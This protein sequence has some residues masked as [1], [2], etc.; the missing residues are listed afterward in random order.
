MFIQ[1]PK[2]EVFSDSLV[3][4]SLLSNPPAARP[5]DSCALFRSPTPAGNKL[6]GH[7]TRVLAALGKSQDSA[8]WQFDFRA[9]DNEAGK[10]GP[11][12]GF[13]FHYLV[14]S[15][16]DGKFISPEIPLWVVSRQAAA[17]TSPKSLET[18]SSPTLAWTPVPGVPAYHLLLSDQAIDINASKGTVAGASVIWQAITTKASIAYGT[19]DPSGS[20]SQLP[21]PPLSPGVP[22]NLVILN[23]YDGRSALS[24]STK[25]QGLK[26][27]TLQAAAAPLQPARNVAPAQGKILTVSADSAITFKWSKAVAANGAGAA[28]TYQIFIYSLES[29]NGF[30][31]LVPIWHTEVTDT[32]AALDAKRTLLTKRYVWKVF[33]LNAAGASVVGDTTSF[34]YRN[35][36]QTLSLTVKSAGLAGDTLPL[37]DVRISVTPLDG[38]A[39]PLPLFTANNGDAEKV[40]AVGSYVLAFSKDGYSGQSRTVTLGTAAPLKLLQI[41]PSASCRITGHLADQTGSDLVNANVTA[42]GGG[43][44]VTSVSDAQGFFLLGVAPGTYA[45]SISKPD[46]QPRP[47]TTFG[48]AA[49]KSVDLGRLTLVK[50][51]GSLSGTVSNDKG[52][53][54][55][56]CQIAIKNAAATVVRSL[57]TDDKGVFSAFLAPGAYTVAAAK[58]G[59]TSD[60]KAVQL[61]ESA[62]LAFTLASGASLIK[63]RISLLSRPT[64]S[65]SQST[66][67]P[68]AAL[69]LVDKLRGTTQRTE[70]DLRGEYSL[71]ADPGTYL[72]KAARP[73]KALPESALVQITGTR[74]T[75][76]QDLALQGFASIQGTLR[77]SPDTT[78]D[79]GG[80]SVNLLSASGLNVAASATPQRA[81][82]T[83]SAG[84]MVY[85][86]E[87][88][89]DGD[90]RLTCGFAGFGL[91]AE[92]LV[93]IRNALWKTGLDLTLKQAI[94]SVTFAMT[95]GGKTADGTIR[96][97]TP[98][99]LE[100][101]AGRKLA[102]AAAGTY[103]L[104]AAPDD[105]S[106]VP[107][108]RYSFFLPAGGFADTTLALAFPFS[109]QSVPLAFNN[110]EAELSMEAGAGIDSML[111]IHG[112]GA[113]TDTFQ[114]PAAQLSGSAGKR[115]LRFRPGAQGGLLTYY[116]VIHAGALLYS[117]EEPA[118]RFHAQV[119]PSRDLSLLKLATT[120]SLRLAANSEGEIFLHAYDAAGRRLDSAVDDRGTIAWSVDGALGVKLDRHSQRTLIYRTSSPSMALAKRGAAAAEGWGKLSV[121]VGL[122]GVTRTLELPTRV[123]SAV[124]NKLVLSSTLGEA[125]D[126]PDPASFGLFVSG[127]DTTTFPP[128][129]VQPN[130]AITLLP[131]KAG[132]V[133]EMQ[134]TLDPRFIGPVHILARH[135]NPDGSEAATELGAY[136]DSLARGLNVGQTLSLRDTTRA[137][138]H[139]DRLQL[140]LEDSAFAGA[141]QALLRLYKR[142]VA[143]TFSSGVT[144]AVA[145]D[146]YEISN[147]SGITFSKPPRITVGLPAGSEDRVNRLE[148]FDALS[149]EWKDLG[150]SVAR[151]RTSDGHPA[152]SA[153][154]PELDGSYYGLLTASRG[155]TAGEVQII[156]NPFSPLVMATHDGNTQYGARIRVHPES[157]RSAEVI[158][159]VKIY[160]LDGELVRTLVDHKT[161]AKAPIDFYWDGRADGGRWVRNGRYLL[162]VSVGTTGSA[163]QKHTLRSVVVFQ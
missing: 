90:Y 134:V 124:V 87:G 39:S 51:Q 155:L 69:E 1:A 109:H 4:I 14:A 148:R 93:S 85:S 153:D 100:L 57:L 74:G 52:A 158:I 20:F 112:Y 136:R 53:N 114:V 23:N 106:L 3:R 139:D 55:A 135:I 11:Q 46:Y 15:C 163:K 141:D 103:T 150:D 125:A 126:L 138:F 147:P 70:S 32:S 156:P 36:V 159:A 92:P 63:G 142:S 61:T 41:M 107:L 127:F 131:A 18:S 7:A 38:G 113:A 137:F 54:L 24:T 60:Q 128:T 79:P 27:F 99:A 119:T 95:T 9:S 132:S 84:A 88:V 162:K 67:L 154:L 37:G 133:R 144:Y 80:V 17:I 104:N 50:A 62:N 117:N 65:T 78:V 110:G 6:E 16:Q 45:V 48:V 108:I 56:G 82:E 58:T 19:P 98:Q 44:T 115:T 81:P 120:D 26:L 47:D 75:L 160:N 145:G 143:K 29:Q 157:D 116:F 121:T 140:D 149:L 30:D 111:I 94:K 12:L 97:I 35:D 21:A 152:L 49:G 161:V 122:D 83:G 146:L 89:P 73:G 25:A 86:L 2:S 118:R 34:Q 33:A 72:L 66:P 64:A 76:A 10:S 28:N 22:Y 96:L 151:S 130:P 68:A 42:A 8:A 40:L 102:Q 31:V 59:F 71:S 129:P 101:P 91:D 77:L 43:K 13:G 123:V 5:P 105:A